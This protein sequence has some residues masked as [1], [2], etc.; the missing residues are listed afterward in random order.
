LDQK[1]L[2]HFTLKWK[3]SPN[4]LRLGKKKDAIR[5]KGGRVENG[6][7][8]QDHEEKGAQAEKVN[9]RNQMEK[10][11][12]QR[13]KKQ[14]KGGNASWDDFVRRTGLRVEKGGNE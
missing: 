13:L 14:K 7:K 10:P 11:L 9:G 2:Y 5:N 1:K 6:K 12:G 8:G 4:L 3:L